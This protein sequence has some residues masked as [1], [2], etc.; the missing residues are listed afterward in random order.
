M[1]NP[2]LPELKPVPVLSEFA[3]FTSLLYF[4]TFT[5]FTLALPTSKIVSVF[6]ISDLSD[7]KQGPVSSYKQM[8]G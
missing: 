4:F 2:K 6:W 5:L 3:L 1:Q 7:I 8:E